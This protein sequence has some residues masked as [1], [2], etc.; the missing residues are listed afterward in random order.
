M[1][2]SASV[3]QVELRSATEESLPDWLLANENPGACELG[4]QVVPFCRHG[5]RQSLPELHAITATFVMGSLC[6]TPSHCHMAPIELALASQ[7]NQ[8]IV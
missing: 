5:P 1:T 6:C 2:E 8:Y 4:F 7:V 3:A